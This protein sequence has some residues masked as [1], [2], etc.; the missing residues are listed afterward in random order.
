MLPFKSKD[1]MVNPFEDPETQAYADQFAIVW[2]MMVKVQ[3]RMADQQKVDELLRDVFG[4]NAR[5]VEEP[6]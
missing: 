2:K 3:E 6:E 1:D 4:P 5:E